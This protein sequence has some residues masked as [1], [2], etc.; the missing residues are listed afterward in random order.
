MSKTIS[1]DSTQALK[2]GRMQA[3]IVGLVVVLI[4]TAADWAF[5]WR[6]NKEL[7]AKVQ[8]LSKENQQ[9]KIDNDEAQK[10]IDQLTQSAADITKALPTVEKALSSLESQVDDLEHDDS[11]SDSMEHFLLVDKVKTATKDVRS[12]LSTLTD[13]SQALKNSPPTPHVETTPAPVPKPIT[14]Y[15][16]NTG[17]KYHRDGCQYLSRSRIPIKLSEAKDQGYTPCSKCSPPE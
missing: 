11:D 13:K 14:V 12:A 7:E 16:T 17:K 15:V 1:M 8:T 2:R 5:E 9:I 6:S 3:G 10:R 4:V